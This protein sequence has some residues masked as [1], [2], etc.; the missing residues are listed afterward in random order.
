MPENKLAS[1]LGLCTKAGKCAFGENACTEKIR[2]QKAKLV[3][4]DDRAGVNTSKRIRDAC[5]FHGVK[6]VTFDGAQNDLASACGKK[7]VVLAVTD[8]GFAQ[9]LARLADA[10]PE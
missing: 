2:A 10:Q 1:M 3:F 4:L 9:A 6:L 8:E 5:A 7:A